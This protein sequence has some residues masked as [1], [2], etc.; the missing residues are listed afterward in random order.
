MYSVEFVTDA[1]QLADT[2][3]RVQ[4]FIVKESFSVIFDQTQEQIAWLKEVMS[5]AKAFLWHTTCETTL[6]EPE[7]RSTVICAP[8]RK[9]PPKVSLASAFGKYVVS[10][11][12]S[13]YYSNFI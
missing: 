5:E 8:D 10:K 2:H 13:I 7:K 12:V 4:R 11:R 3:Q 9:K 6:L 1:R